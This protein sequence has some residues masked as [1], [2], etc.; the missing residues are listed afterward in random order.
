[1]GFQGNSKKGKFLL[2]CGL[3]IIGM[4]SMGL[5]SLTA[6]TG[7]LSFGGTNFNGYDDDTNSF[8]LTNNYVDANMSAF[9]F[10]FIPNGSFT[11]PVVE[12]DFNITWP[13][14]DISNM[15]FTNVSSLNNTG[16]I[17]VKLTIPKGLN[18]IDENFNE[19][20]FNIGEID[21]S[22]TATNTSNFS[23]FNT[24]INL[25]A[26]DIQVE[27]NLEFHNNKIGIEVADDDPINIS[28]GTTV[29]AF[30]G[31]AVEIV[32][33]YEN[34]F[35]NDSFEFNNHDIEAILYIDDDEIESENGEDDVEGG[36]VGELTFSFD[37]DDYDEDEYDV[38]IELTGTE[39]NG[40]LHGEVFEFEFSLTEETAPA[41]GDADND[42]VTDDLD[43]CPDTLVLCDVDE[44][45]C[46]LDN[47]N[48]GICNGVDTTPDGEEE[49]EEAGEDL[50]SG[51]EE[52]EAEEETEEDE[53]VEDEI[54]DK[55]V[56]SWP[57]IFGLI[58]GVIGTGLFF[59]L[60][61]L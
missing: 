52:E 31:D 1:M 30:I 9:V 56:S 2:V 24:G 51:L 4:V 37:L 29:D 36:E 27:N 19:V 41:P 39:E 54:E 44:A 17:P 21:I 46:E 14:G 26:I 5:A 47:D 53:I 16:S 55:E 10:D 43:L 22:A 7:V 18:A 23:T 34:D 12:G 32:V 57:F 15:T 49:E 40:G 25:I 50:E 28:D 42:G 20:S 35:S 59:I 38:K 33:R 8:T 13:S 48:D 60:T 45:G 61:R 11:N 3:F 58:V 6:S